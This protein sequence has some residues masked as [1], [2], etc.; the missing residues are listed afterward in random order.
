MI[1]L[2]VIVLFGGFAAVALWGVLR[3]FLG[4]AAERRRRQELLR[5]ADQIERDEAA[6][7]GGSPEHPIDI[8]TPAV[9]ESMAASHTCSVCNSDLRLDQHTAETIGQANLRVAKMTCV[10]CSRPRNLYFRLQMTRLH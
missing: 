5:Q 3:G 9:V 1:R 4:R 10:Q 6:L 8:D 7:P 2:I